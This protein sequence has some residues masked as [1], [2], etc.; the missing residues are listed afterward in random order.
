MQTIAIANQKGGTGKTTTTV[1]MG[2]ALAKQGYRVLLI[3]YDSQGNLTTYLNGNRVGGVEYTITD[4]MQRAMEDEFVM[5]DKF[6]RHHEDGV[7]YIA[8]NVHMASLDMALFNTLS[9]ESILRYALEP[10]QQRY[11]YCLIDCG[12]HL[13]IVNVNA[14]TAANSVLIPVQAQ[15]FAFDGLDD[16]VKSIHRVRRKLN[17]SLTIEGVVMTLVDHRTN[18]CKAI[19]EEARRNQQCN[20]HIF[21]T[22]IPYNIRTAES[23]AAGHSVLMYDP[24]CKG[25][26]A[27]TQLTKE[28]LNNAKEREITRTADLDAISR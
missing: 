20:L 15:K 12:P 4:L 25:A 28:V 7:D 16:L 8:S 18:L 23:S 21:S 5:P 14:F 27:Y 3:D 22:E 26:E 17:P 10:F 24:K 9:R 1:N 19:C 13:G 6:V 2:A 11:D